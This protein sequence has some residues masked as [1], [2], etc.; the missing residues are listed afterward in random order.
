MRYY[1]IVITN[2]TTGAILRPAAFASLNLPA[3]YT[4]FVNNKSLPAALNVEFDI[5][6][7]AYAQPRGAAFVRIWGISLQEISQATNLNG[8]NIA[9]YG[10]MQ[11]GLPLANASQSGLLVQGTILQAYGNWVGADMTLDMQV[12]T[13]TNAAGPTGASPPKNIV[14]NWKAGTPL[15]TAIKNTLTVAYSGVAADINIS[16]NLVLAHD[17]PGFYGSIVQFAQYVKQK[18]IDI[19]GGTYQGVDITLKQNKFIVADGTT[20]TAPIQILFTDLIGQPTWVGPQEIHVPLIM[21]ADLSVLAYI[22]MPKTQL[23]TG[24]NTL[25]Q[26]RNQ[27]AQQGQFRIKEIHH[28][29]NYRQPDGAS[30]VTNVYAYPVGSN[31]Q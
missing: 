24:S 28:F 1:S 16:P 13:A 30:W 11:K 26:Y 27:S 29:G 21:R 7:V 4:S 17:E 14:L 3:S 9:V 8:M 12:T 10:G 18:S 19:V 23:S 6:V 5:P 31:G 2:P 22:Q 20:A 15:A 25:S